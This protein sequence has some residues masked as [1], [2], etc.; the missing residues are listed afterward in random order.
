MDCTKVLGAVGWEDNEVEQG[1]EGPLL[2][3]GEKE[4]GSSYSKEGGEGGRRGESEKF[5]FID[6]SKGELRLM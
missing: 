3:E 6:L 1:G 5:L 4:G 2:L